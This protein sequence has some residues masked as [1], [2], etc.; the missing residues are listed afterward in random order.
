MK[1]RSDGVAAPM[2]RPQRGLPQQAAGGKAFVAVEDVWRRVP[3]QVVGRLI[4]R[5]SLLA[6]RW[7]DEQGRKGGL[8]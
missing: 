7:L 3:Q 2:R 4:H 8:P 6:R 5:L 1:Q